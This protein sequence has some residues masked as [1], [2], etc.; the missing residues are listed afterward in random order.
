MAKKTLLNAV[1]IPAAGTV[2]TTPVGSFADV[3]DLELYASFVYGSGGTSVDAYVQTTLDGTNWFDI[4]EFHFTTASAKKA[5]SVSSSGDL[6]TNPTLTDGALAADTVLSGLIGEQLRIKQVV[7][8]TYVASTLSIT[9]ETRTAPGGGGGTVAATIGDGANVTQ[10]ALADA[11]VAA[12][13]AGSISAKLR[14]LTTQ[15]AAQLPAALGQGTAAQSL[16]VVD[17]LDVFT[18]PDNSIVSVTNAST[19]LVA[20]AGAGVRQRETILYNAGAQT[21]SIREG[22]APTAGT[23]FPLVAGAVLRLE[24]LLAV[25]GIVASGTCN[26]AILSEA[27]S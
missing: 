9:A 4:A 23:H 27:R 11:A 2:T 6:T 5:L 12:G 18:S 8:G 13:A 10:G 24:T 16:S 1:A 26:V 21:V 19:A 7:V 15:L 14:R 20:A 22:A 25:N 3:G 17:A